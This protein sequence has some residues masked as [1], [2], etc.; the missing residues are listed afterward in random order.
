MPAGKMMGNGGGPKAGM[1]GPKAG[2]GGP[3]AGMGGPKV[4]DLQMS[5]DGTSKGG[6]KAP[7]DGKGGPKVP[8]DGKGGE[9]KGKGI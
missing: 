9:P 3:K 4:R 7:K 8:K 1:G 2:M 5:K 6:P